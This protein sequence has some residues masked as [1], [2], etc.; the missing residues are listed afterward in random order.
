MGTVNGKPNTYLWQNPSPGLIELLPDSIHKID[1]A[2]LALNPNP[3][4]VAFIETHIISI[5]ASILDALCNNLAENKSF[6]AIVLLEKL[7]ASSSVGHITAESIK[8]G[9]LSRNS[10]AGKLIKTYPEHIHWP[11]LS[12]NSS[13]EAVNLLLTNTDKIDWDNASYNEAS[14]IIELVIEQYYYRIDNG[15]ADYNMNGLSNNQNPMAIAFLEVHPDKISW[16]N[17]CANP[18]SV[19]MELLLSVCSANFENTKKILWTML[20]MNQHPIA[21]QLIYERP[22][23]NYWALSANA[24]PMAMELLSAAPTPTGLPNSCSAASVSPN[25]LAANPAIFEKSSVAR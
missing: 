25:Y 21:V 11:S 12:R 6:A 24:N 1:W 5:P 16:F 15:W 3:D 19:A 22:I 18:S 13:P 14:E 10:F 4:A 2:S 9:A 20:E 8:P 23:Q 17:L 7:I